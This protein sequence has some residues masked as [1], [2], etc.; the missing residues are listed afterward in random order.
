MSDDAQ[1]KIGELRGEITGIN[2]RLSEHGKALTNIFAKMESNQKQLL[3]EIRSPHCEQEARIET[4]EKTA[5]DGAALARGNADSLKPIL[6]ER[7]D[8]AADS[9]DTRREWRRLAFLLLGFMA[10]AVLGGLMV[11]CM[12]Q[13][14]WQPD[15]ASVVEAAADREGEQGE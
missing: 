13:V 9:K 10:C 2:T 1:F 7:A 11:R 12:P 14:P 5:G 4:V 15:P 6:K 3:G 8:A